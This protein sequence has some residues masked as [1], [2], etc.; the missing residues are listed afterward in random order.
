MIGERQASC[1]PGRGSDAAQTFDVRAYRD[2]LGRFAT[3][4]VIVTAKLAD[5]ELSGMTANSFSS[6]S[7]D[8]PLVLFSV[9]QTTKSGAALLRA[10]GYGISILRSDQQ[11]LSNQF[12]RVSS[13]RWHSTEWV[14]G[15]A[16]AP[17]I[18]GAFARFECE[19]YASYD[20]GDHVIVVVR[21]LKFAIANDKMDPLVFFRGRYRHLSH[22][23]GQ[24]VP[25]DWPLPIY[26]G[27]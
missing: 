21:V 20:G 4:I 23:D 27:W 15:H 22:E 3:G 2:A 5:G 24:L 8:P 17:F 9:Q 12:A 16:G 6:V 26:Y 13:D 25:Q 10:K 18:R 1:E 7:I 11:H 14:E 19:P